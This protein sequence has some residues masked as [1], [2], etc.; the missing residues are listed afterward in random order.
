MKQYI[1]SILVATLMVITGVYQIQ[2]VQSQTGT[3]ETKNKHIVQSVTKED[4][5]MFN[6]VPESIKIDIIKEEENNNYI[7]MQATAYTKSREEGTHKGIT[8]SGIP[9]SRGI[10]SVDPKTI[11]LGTRL[12]IED[13]GHALAADTGGAIKDNRIDLYMETKKEAFDFGRR[14]VKVWIIEEDNKYIK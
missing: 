9:V 8:K 5:T 14:D 3:T 4:V 7:I 1:I 13:Y 11:P 6:A 12:F 2:Q 10:V